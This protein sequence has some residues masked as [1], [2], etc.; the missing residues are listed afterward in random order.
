MAE[1]HVPQGEFSHL[2]QS[3]LLVHLCD[4][5]IKMNCTE[6]KEVNL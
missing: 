2:A 3:L 1:T 4:N 6:V 5:F